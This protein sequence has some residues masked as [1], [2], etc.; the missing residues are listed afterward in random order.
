MLDPFVVKFLI[1]ALVIIAGMWSLDHAVPLL[2][3]WRRRRR[4]R[5][6]YHGWRD[7]SNRM[8]LRRAHSSPTSST[9]SHCGRTPRNAKSEQ[10]EG[11]LQKIRPRPLK[12]STFQRRRLSS[13]G[14]AALL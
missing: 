11:G 12:P 8:L 7:H 14:R 4:R 2:S 3:H 6:R 13:V 10:V 1:L 9:V 5:A